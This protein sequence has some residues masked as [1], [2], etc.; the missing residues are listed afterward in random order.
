MSAEPDYTPPLSLTDTVGRAVETL[1]QRYT[2]C[3]FRY[4]PC[5]DPVAMTADPAEIESIVEAFAS[6]SAAALPAGAELQIDVCPKSVQDSFSEHCFSAPRG[7][8]AAISFSDTGAFSETIAGPEGS[9]PGLA[10]AYE[11]IKKNG[12]IVSAH[13]I[14]GIG[15]T[16]RILLPILPLGEPETSVPDAMDEP[17]GSETVLLVEDVGEV[18]EFLRSILTSRG[19]RVLGARNGSDAI[20]LA[21]RFRGEIQLLLTDLAIPGVSAR[22]MIDC[23]VSLRPGI[24]VLRMSGY[25]GN[26]SA[27]ICLQKPFSPG[28]LLRQIRRL[29]DG[30]AD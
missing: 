30:P 9:S 5:L 14:S 10:H 17:G 28:V 23:I 29:L 2:A 3:V 20:V 27:P 8:Y 12:G 21:T 1:R 18:R 7:K 16:V 4:S 15:S 11:L 22:E 6:A 26:D 24:A 19:Y 13:R 25:Q